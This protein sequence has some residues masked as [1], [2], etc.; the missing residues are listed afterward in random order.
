MRT[1]RQTLNLAHRGRATPHRAARRR[2]LLGLAVA[3]LAAARPGTGR[4]AEPPTYP[5]K[6]VRFII[7]FPP[8]GSTD[9]VGRIV[10][11]RLG[12][13][14]GQPLVIENRGGGGGSIGAEALANAT[15]DGYTIGM[16]TVSTH[17][18]NP[19][20]SRYPHYDPIR[21]FIPITNLAAVPNV[22]AVNPQLPVGDM[23]AFLALL[24]AQPGKLSYASSGTGGV[25]HMMGELFLSV[26]G[27]SMVHVPYRGAG[28]AINDVIAG[29]VPVLFDNLPSSI[30]HIRGGRLRALAVAAPERLAALPGVPTFAE[31]GMPAVND[32]A[33]YGL[34]APAGTPAAAIE[35]VSAAALRA[36]RDPVVIQRLLQQSA[37]PIGNSQAAFAAQIRGELDKWQRVVRER[38]IQ[39]D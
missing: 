32:R 24:R 30:E 34:V 39:L 33:W 29:Q 38:G 20:T 7:P 8:G 11:E 6:P 37:F 16:A 26:S 28:P 18:T 1:R 21:D 3:G 4:A 14:L 2:V 36:L 5:A 27:T 31:I 22:L 17:G 15:A 35:A 10:A 19:V 12:P 13:E 23:A 9:I 25:G